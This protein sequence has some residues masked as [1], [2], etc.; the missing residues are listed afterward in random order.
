[1]LR[2]AWS[3]WTLTSSLLLQNGKL[4]PT[5]GHS[6]RDGLNNLMDTEMT[7]EHTPSEHPSPRERAREAASIL[8]WL[9]PAF[10]QRCPETALFRLASRHP[11][12][13]IQTPL[14]QEF[15]YEGIQPNTHLGGPRGFT[16]GQ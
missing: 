3:V 13:F 6:I 9:A 8:L 15:P 2:G 7:V 4:R 5:C 11:S 14:N 10:T 1:M 16:F 12:T